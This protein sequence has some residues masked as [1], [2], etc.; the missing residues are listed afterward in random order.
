MSYWGQ[1][2]RDTV[3]RV[4]ELS[5]G[6]LFSMEEPDE[7]T[8][9]PS[10]FHTTRGTAMEDWYRVGGTAH[11]GRISEAK[12]LASAI[13]DPQVRAVS[14]L[15]LANIQV[16][17]GDLPGAEETL[18]GVRGTLDTSAVDSRLAYGYTQKGD[19]G[20]AER[21][22]L[23]IPD[24]EKRCEA[25]ASVALFVFR[26][27]DSA[28][29]RRLLAIAEDLAFM[30]RPSH[31]RDFLIERVGMVYAWTG[32]VVEAQTMFLQFT[33][34]GRYETVMSPLDQGTEPGPGGKAPSLRRPSVAR[35]F[36]LSRRAATQRERGPGG[37]GTPPQE[38]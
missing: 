33:E 20:S 6:G 1:Y 25:V 10:L 11:R 8:L 34:P 24:P 38:K 35:A 29:S 13:R 5:K 17:Q 2:R 12:A 9:F 32:C 37:E 26:A 16:L 31:R 28:T 36:P 14:I 19:L 7:A 27:G 30:A 18:G 4:V 22:S 3:S 23:L 15:E 21:D